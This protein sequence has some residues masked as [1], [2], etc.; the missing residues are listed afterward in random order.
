MAHYV[1]LAGCYE[2]FGF[3]CK[4]KKNSQRLSAQRL[5][6]R[7]VSHRGAKKWLAGGLFRAYANNPGEK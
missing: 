2:D 1:G 3:Y 7:R 6:L 4:G 5:S